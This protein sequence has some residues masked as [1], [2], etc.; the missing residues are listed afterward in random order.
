MKHLLIITCCVVFLFAERIEITS[1]ELKAY[2]TKKE[3]HFIGD[4]NA[5]QKKR[6]IHGD[7]IVVY[8]N[9][10]N[11]AKM[12]VA[13]GHVTFRVEH[14]GFL[15]IGRADTIRYTPLTSVYILQ[16]NAEVE[17]V[18]NKR[19]LK[20]SRIVIDTRTGQAILESGR[21]KNKKNKPV[22]LIFETDTTH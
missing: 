2:E 10:D 16:G 3:I 5:S 20:G 19:T 8:L 18:K 9:K 4:A 22:K 13:K 12:Y 1:D 7:H 6:W 11:R 15:Y 14:N 17:D 21:N